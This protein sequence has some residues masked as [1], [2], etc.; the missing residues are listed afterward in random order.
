MEAN[1]M[2]LNLNKLECATGGEL[3]GEQQRKILLL[4]SLSK[5]KNVDM[6]SLLIFFQSNLEVNQ[7]IRD[8]WW[9]VKAT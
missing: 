5:G 6:E 9:W 2:E 8:N 1:T 7:F 4:I 3:T